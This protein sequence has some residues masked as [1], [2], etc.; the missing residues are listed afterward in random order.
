M[1]KIK[2]LTL[3]HYPLSRSA[4]VRFLLEEL[5]FDYELV[6]VNMLRGEGMSE[7]HMARNPNH[8]VPV[9]DI[10]YDDES[11]QTLIESGA[12]ILWLA[13]AFPSA[14]LAPVVEDF[15]ARAEYTQ[16]ILFQAAHVDMSLW[17]VRL[18]ETLFPEPVRSQPIAAFNRDKLERE[19]IPQMEARVSAHDWICGDTFTAADCIAAQN[20]NWM[21]AYGLAKTGPLRDYMHRL[22]ARPAFARAFAD[23]KDFER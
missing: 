1:A 3:Y 22:K 5:G 12:M 11:Q 19:M 16:Q 15:R 21:R 20:V 8:A 23:A 2:H 7:A 10:A 14:G 18:N 4:R 9:L 13:D 6:N 17:Q